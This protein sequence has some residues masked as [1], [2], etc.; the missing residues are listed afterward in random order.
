MDKEIADYS[1]YVVAFIP[2][3]IK[4]NGTLNT[5]KHVGELNKKSVIIN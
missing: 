5:L 4:S 1:D 2:K 3:G